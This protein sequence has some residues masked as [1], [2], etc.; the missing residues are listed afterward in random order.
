LG[1]TLN[2]FSVFLIGDLDVIGDLDLLLPRGSIFTAPNLFFPVINKMSITGKNK[3][4]AVNME[5]LGKS[6]SKSPMT[7]KSPMRKTEKIFN[8]K[9][10]VKLAALFQTL[11][12]LK[13]Q[14]E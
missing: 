7:S 2:I 3:F 5:P 10:K 11:S 9:P 6:R 4:G 14:N 1:F 8:V 12:S 13:H